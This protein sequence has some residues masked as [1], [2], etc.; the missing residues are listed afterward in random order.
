MEMLFSY[1]TLKFKRFDFITEDGHS[2]Y[3]FEDR[4]GVE[5]MKYSRWGFHAVK[6]SRLAEG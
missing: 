4:Y 1:F 5:Y 3:V 2:V 6:K